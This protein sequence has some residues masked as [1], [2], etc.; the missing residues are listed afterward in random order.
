VTSPRPSPI[1][2]RVRRFLTET[3]RH[4]AIATVDPDGGPR[5]TLTWFRLD[6]EGSL[7]V[8]SRHGRRWPAN[9]ERDGRAAL[10][11][12][13]ADDPDR[14]VGLTARL[15]ETI[16]DVERAREDIVALA[17]VYRPEGPDPADIAAY[18]SQPRVMYRFEI[19]GVHDH[20][21]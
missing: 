16:D 2:D 20:L 1:P 21:E 13:D 19:T 18:R 15:A 8:N 10:A 12:V 7:W 11:I 17:H 3:P 6:D 9:V 5:Q 4:A 14:W